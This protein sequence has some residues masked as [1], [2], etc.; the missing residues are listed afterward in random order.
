VQLHGT[1]VSLATLASVVLSDHMKGKTTRKT[2]H[3]A[4]AKKPVVPLQHNITPRDT[5]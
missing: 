1:H 5:R 4:D 3:F 2:L